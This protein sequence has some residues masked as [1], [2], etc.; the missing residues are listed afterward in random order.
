MIICA[1]IILKSETHNLLRECSEKCQ[2][3]GQL[4]YSGAHSHFGK[5][6]GHVAALS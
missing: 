2:K 3:G 4:V 5:K 1:I 6:G